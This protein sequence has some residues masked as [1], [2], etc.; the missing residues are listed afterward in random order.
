MA[1]RCLKPQT[2]NEL[3]DHIDQD[4]CRTD[5]VG[6]RLLHFHEEDTIQMREVQAA[7]VFCGPGHDFRARRVTG[8]V[9]GSLE[10]KKHVGLVPCVFA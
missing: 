1:S 8:H 4:T 7:A 9:C 3:T 6:W 5:T 10:F 2:F